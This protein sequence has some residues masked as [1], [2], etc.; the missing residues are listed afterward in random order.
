M[1]EISADLK[2]TPESSAHLEMSGAAD[3]P[4]PSTPSAEQKVLQ[5]LG[6]G[7]QFLW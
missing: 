5:Q 6:T 7:T 2:I 1:Y 3:S 4:N